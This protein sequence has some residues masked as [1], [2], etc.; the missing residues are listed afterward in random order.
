MELKQAK[1]IVDV[2]Q[3]HGVEGISLSEDY[4]GRGMYGRTTAAVCIDSLMQI[5]MMGWAA[6]AIESLGVGARITAMDVESWSIDNM[7]MG[8]VIY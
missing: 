4:S 7:G 3:D 5:A 6:G 1:L 8:Y 2:L